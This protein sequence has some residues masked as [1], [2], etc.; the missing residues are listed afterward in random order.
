[1]QDKT[2]IMERIDTELAGCYELQPLVRRDSRGAFTKIFNQ[3]IFKELGLATDFK[4]EYYSSSV[5][6]VLRGLHFQI[7]PADHV[8]VVTCVSGQVLDV[9][10]DIRKGSPTYGKFHLCK[11]N[12]ERGNMLYLP[13]GFAHG[14]YTLSSQAL[15]LY[16]VTSE[17]APNCDGGIRW[18]SVGIPWP[19]DEERILSERDKVFP[20]LKDFET[21]FS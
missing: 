6:G 18:D 15:L 9:A 5:K 17:Y 16:M 3:G 10:V 7:P 1:M 19:E 2:G 8:K 4:E 12:G 20:L 14:F 13:Q 21:P 11:L